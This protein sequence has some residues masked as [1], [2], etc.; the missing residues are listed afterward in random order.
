MGTATIQRQ[1]LAAGAWIHQMMVYLKNHP[2]GFAGADMLWLL[3]TWAIV[4]RNWGNTGDP[5][6][7]GD[8]YVASMKR[9][10]PADEKITATTPLVAGMPDYKE[11]IK[12]S[13]RLYRELSDLMSKMD[14]Q[15]AD[16]ANTFKH[17]LAM[18]R[19]QLR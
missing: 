19:H 10:L 1:H 13:Q 4:G 18:L 16:R 11:D 17:S 5:K 12:A 14:S 15:G 6:S 8:H 3:K 2:K 9:F 7:S